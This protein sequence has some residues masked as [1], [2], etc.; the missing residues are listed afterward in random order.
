[1]ARTHGH[2]NPD[3]TRDE[4]IL[5]L[6]LYFE[7]G[8]ALPSP[9]DARVR[10]L[11]ELLRT[12]PYHSGNSRKES[13]R[14]PDGVAFRLQNLHNVATGRGLGNVSAMDRKIWAEF[15]SRPHEVRTLAQ[16]TKAGINYTSALPDHTSPNDG[17]E[18]LEGR[19]L[20]AIHKA[21]ERNPNARKNCWHRGA[22]PGV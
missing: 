21:R 13:F 22:E 20:T 18:F 9:R 14:N 8:D 11:S 5:A 17:E 2:G 3:W 15:G 1:M 10:Q 12:L 6:A 7:C 4:T 19:L 16:L